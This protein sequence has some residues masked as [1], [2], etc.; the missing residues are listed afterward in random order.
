MSELFANEKSHSAHQIGPCIVDN[1]SIYVAIGYGLDKSEAQNLNSTLGSVIRMDKLN[2]MPLK[3]NPF[4]VDDN[5]ITSHDYIWAYGFRNIFGL[6]KVNDEIFYTQNGGNIDTF[7]KLEKGKNYL[8]NGT[9]ISIAANASYVFSP[10]QGLV[11]ITYIDDD[12]EFPL[13]F[14]NKFYIISTGSPWEIGPGK[15]GKNIW[16]LDYD[17][18]NDNLNSSPYELLKFD[19]DYLQL[20]VFN[21]FFEDSLFFFGIMP[22]KNFKTNIFKINYLK[23]FNHSNL[24]T[25]SS[26]AIDLIKKHNCTNCH[27]I[28]KFGKDGSEHGPLIDI[29]YFTKKLKDLNSSEY[30]EKVDALNKNEKN[31]KIKKIRNEILESND[32]DKI[33]LWLKNYLTNPKLDNLNNQMPNLNITYE[34]AEIL[35]KYLLGNEE[36]FEKLNSSSI[37]KIFKHFA[38]SLLPEIR[39]R[40]LFIF[41]IAGIFLSIFVFYIFIFFKKRFN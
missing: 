1:K 17:F 8:W 23:N 30:K 38:K 6:V 19:G 35:A 10:S 16:V 4:F 26:T 27:I 2:F 11:S 31:S 41:F 7:G 5:K 3:D 14:K 20:P 18:K 29:F 37:E 13:E 33:S 40:H 39:Y 9:D 22:D 24:L 32:Y 15:K 25:S 34:E 21:T 12:N 28:E 36:N